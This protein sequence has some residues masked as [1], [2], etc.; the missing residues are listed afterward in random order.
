MSEKQ[1]EPFWSE[2]LRKGLQVVRSKGSHLFDDR[3]RKCIDFLTG[4]N[5]GNLGWGNRDIKAAISRFKGPEY[6]YPYYLYGPWTELAK[7]LAELTPGKLKKS[8]RA[9]GDTEAVEI[10]LQVAMVYTKRRKFISISCRIASR[11]NHRLI[12]RRRTG[13]RSSISAS[14]SPT[15]S[16]CRRYAGSARSTEPCSS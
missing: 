2:T 6:V 4:W 10:A 5:V 15:K 12:T 1:T 16:S 14:L 8:F 13:W 9:T 7:L 11:S 3:G